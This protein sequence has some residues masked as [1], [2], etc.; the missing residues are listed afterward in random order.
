M[1]VISIPFRPAVAG[2][3]GQ[4]FN[5][6]MLLSVRS[7]QLRWR[8]ALF[9]WFSAPEQPNRPFPTAASWSFLFKALPVAPLFW[10][11]KILRQGKEKK[12][13]QAPRYFFTWQ[14]GRV[15]C[16]VP[17]PGFITPPRADP[18]PQPSPFA[19]LRWQE[20]TAAV[21]AAAAP[22]GRE[23][24]VAAGVCPPGLGEH[25]RHRAVSPRPLLRRRGARLR[26][27]PFKSFR[28]PL[29]A[30]RPA[31]LIGSPRC[32]SPA[33]PVSAT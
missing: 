25:R 32:R 1:C 15:P 17:P 19:P 23:G 4:H 27:F 31:P 24:E 2:E 8:R 9:R 22:G 33:V 7:V 29:R 16:A 28:P 5:V 14:L 12:K 10:Q 20:A 26:R 18:G 3:A 30:P 13:K 21:P 11:K 6:Q